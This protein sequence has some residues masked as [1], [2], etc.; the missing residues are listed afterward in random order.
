MMAAA[1]MWAISGIAPAWEERQVASV[2]EDVRGS[3]SGM[4]HELTELSHKLRTVCC[5]GNAWKDLKSTY[6]V[7]KQQSAYDKILSAADI[8]LGSLDVVST[9]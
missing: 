7:K 9:F 6:K 5:M 3:R 8:F 4:V 1:G 2:R